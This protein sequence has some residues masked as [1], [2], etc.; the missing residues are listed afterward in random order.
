MRL[1]RNFTR[2]SEIATNLRCS[3][4]VWC[5]DHIKEIRMFRWRTKQCPCDSHAEGLQD[6]YIRKGVLSLSSR[7]L[8]RDLVLWL[9]FLSAWMNRRLQHVPKSSSRRTTNEIMMNLPF[10]TYNVWIHLDVNCYVIQCYIIISNYFLY[11]WGKAL[12]NNFALLRLL[13]ANC[14]FHTYDHALW[15]NSNMWTSTFSTSQME[16]PMFLWKS[17]C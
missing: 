10:S 2:F 6:S 9:T 5:G 1:S 17:R 12:N 15:W 11:S 4:F 7:A 16:Y 8:S 14:E 3:V 13:L